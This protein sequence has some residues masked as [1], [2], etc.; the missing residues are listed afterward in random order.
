MKDPKTYRPTDCAFVEA[1][2]DKTFEELNPTLRSLM[3]KM[4]G[5]RLPTD[6]FH[7]ALCD[8]YEKP[9]AYVELNDECHFV[10]LKSG[11]SKTVH[12]ES[13]RNF[14]LYLRSIGI[15]ERT[16]KIILLCHYGDGTLTGKGENRLSA[17]QTRIRYALLINEA[18]RELNQ[19]KIVRQCFQRFIS[20]GSEKRNTRA[21]Y[22]AY[23]DPTCYVAC[24]IKSLESLVM[25]GRYSHIRTLHIGPMVIGPW[26]RNA[27]GPCD[28][29]WKREIVHINWP[30]L[31]SDIERVNARLTREDYPV[32][33]VAAG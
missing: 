29:D 8:G 22:I 10:S 32:N 26:C 33:A 2:N 11:N 18:N 17:E 31:L 14:I 7:A 30:Y 20:T 4:F 13:I 6:R 24:S 28:T 23:G 5:V 25:G 15:T 19:K 27:K 21:D 9:D 12:Y 1:V 3:E 16:Q